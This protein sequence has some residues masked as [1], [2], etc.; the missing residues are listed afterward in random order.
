MRARTGRTRAGRRPAGAPGG[1]GRKMSGRAGD[2][3]TDQQADPGQGEGRVQAAPEAPPARESAGPRWYPRLAGSAIAGFRNGSRGG[4]K[5]PR[6]SYRHCRRSSP[7]SLDSRVIGPGLAGGRRGHRRPR[8]ETTANT[9]APQ[10]FARRAAVTR[11]ERTRFSKGHSTRHPSHPCRRRYSSELIV[12]A[13]D[14]R[15]GREVRSRTDHIAQTPGGRKPESR[16]S[17][18]TA[19]TIEDPGSTRPGDSGAPRSLILGP[20]RA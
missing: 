17:E 2:P 16:K 19:G 5:R 9:M 8:Q 20:I 3:L 18:I 7:S 13:L 15:A 6:K 1:E 4:R 11:R 10:P 12:S 14:I